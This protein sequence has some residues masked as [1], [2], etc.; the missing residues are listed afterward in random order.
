MEVAVI[1]AALLTTWCFRAWL[2][3]LERREAVRHERRTELVRARADAW[4]ADELIQVK[5]RLQRLELRGLR[6]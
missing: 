4:K 6:P 3:F 1:V 5:E 2:G